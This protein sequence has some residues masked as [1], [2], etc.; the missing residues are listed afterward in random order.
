MIGEKYLS[1]AVHAEEIKTGQLNLVKANTGAGKTYWAL[2]VLAQEVE[3]RNEM[4]YL[5]DTINGGKQIEKNDG[6]E[7]YQTSEL[8][9]LGDGVYFWEEQNIVLMTYAKFGFL[10]SENE[11]YGSTFKIIVCD[12]IQNVIRFSYF[13]K[14]ENEL[15]VHQIAKN[16]LEEI[17]RDNL[18][19]KVIGLSAT[20]ERVE[21]E[22]R[23]PYQYITVDEEVR[24]YETKRTEYYSNLEFLVKNLPKDRIGLIYVG[25]VRK[26]KALVGIAEQRGL[27]AIAIW[28]IRREKEDKM[29]EE[30]LAALNH[31]LEYEELPP[32]Y[33]IVIINASSE[34]SINIRGRI[35]YIVIHSTE[36]EVRTQVRGRYRKD[37]DLLYLFNSNSL[38]VPVEF[39]ERPLFTSDTKE[40][41]RILQMR[42][43][44]GRVVG[45]TTV[46]KRLEEEDYIITRGKRRSDGKIY[47]VISM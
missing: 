14:D 44:C 35:D 23:A 6:I 36:E 41:C 20:P 17:T 32:N 27:R 5:I 43:K 38:K 47:Y 33:N 24:T 46:K 28:S 21:K 19:T 11:D 39:M 8:K 26:M 12:E 34:T 16:R 25:H 30:Q 42:D 1:E 31:I 3:N 10:V 9:L 40:L 7:A 18:N 2:N 22:F 29:T 15:P 45:W 13:G 4:L 37:L